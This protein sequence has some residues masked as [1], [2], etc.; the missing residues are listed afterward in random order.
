MQATDIHTGPQCRHCG[1]PIRGRSDKIFCDANCKNEYHNRFQRERRK[2]I[3]GIDRILKHN[4]RVLKLSLGSATTRK[5]SKEE[6]IQEG[7][8]FE[9]YTH[10]FIN[11]W[12][13]KYCFCY[14]Y[15]FLALIKDRY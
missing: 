2:E 3:E 15:G 4:R 9:Y 6:L 13:E 12:R 7:L 14:D 11:V 10:H 5:V 1:K 8:K